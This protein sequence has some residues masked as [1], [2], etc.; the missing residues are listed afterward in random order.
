MEVE[1]FLEHHGVKGQQWGVRN[2]IRL[3][4]ARKVASGKGT[5]GEKASVLA[6]QSAISL[7]RGHGFQ[8]AAKNDAIR[9]AARKKRIKTG[10]AKVSDILA[11]HGGDSLFNFGGTG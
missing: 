2:E 10:Q 8:G 4:T 1:E 6:K 9:L 5:T 3:Q 11:I 7:I